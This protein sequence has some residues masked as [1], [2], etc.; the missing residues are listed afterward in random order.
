M[1]NR[2]DKLAWFG[3][4][5]AVLTWAIAPRLALAHTVV[6]PKVPAVT[7]S[8]LPPPVYAE[9]SEKKGLTETMQPGQ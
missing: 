1:I 3:V 5:L 9:P 2:L 7:V 6:F 8:V 4:A